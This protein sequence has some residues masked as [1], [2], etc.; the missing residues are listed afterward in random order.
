[1]IQRTVYIVGYN[2]P[3]NNWNFR[4]VYGDETEAQEEANACPYGAGEYWSDDVTFEN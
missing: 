2:D 4:G 1:M 3:E